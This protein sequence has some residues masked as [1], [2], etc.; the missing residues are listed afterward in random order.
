MPLYAPCTDYPE[1][2]DH[3]RELVRNV[4]R[5]CP[6]LGGMILY[7]G[8]SGTGICHSLSLYP[9]RNGPRFCMKDPPGEKIRRL[10]TTILT[11]ARETN[12]DFRVY[13]GP[14]I[15]GEERVP[16]FAHGPEGV[17]SWE[18]FDKLLN[19]AH[20]VS[21]PGAGFGLAGEGFLRLT[22]F[23][24]PENVKKALKRIADAT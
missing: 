20:V 13:L 7:S 5:E 14:Y 12:P 17:G 8:D 9:G 10:V 21:T 18:F 19:K 23:G 16:T 1:V 3:Y 11:T 2:H 4:M 15:W 22:A 24:L 6:D